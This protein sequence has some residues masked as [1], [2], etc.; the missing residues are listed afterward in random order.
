MSDLLAR[1]ARE[2]EVVRDDDDA[3]PCLLEP[4]DLGSDALHVREVETARRLVEHEYARPLQRPCGNGEPLTLSAR[5]GERV[6]T[7]QLLEA[8]TLE[9][10]FNEG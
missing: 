6:P 4:V 3:A 7:A 8:E 10:S 2:L 5:E 9:H 1:G